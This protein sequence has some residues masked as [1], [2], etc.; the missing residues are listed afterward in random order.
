MLKPFKK[1]PILVNLKAFKSVAG[2]VA[3]SFSPSGSCYTLPLGS[4][5]FMTMKLCLLLYR[6]RK[7]KKKKKALHNYII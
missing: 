7:G 3:F 2:H 1:N 4:S 5:I 6:E